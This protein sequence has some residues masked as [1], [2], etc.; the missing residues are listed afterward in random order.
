MLYLQQNKMEI[1][2]L[3]PEE[4]LNYFIVIWNLDRDSCYEEILEEL[5]WDESLQELYKQVLLEK[6]PQVLKNKSQKILERL[7]DF[8]SERLCAFQKFCN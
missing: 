4:M 6:N 1:N 3:T 7:S 8:K 2:S 5:K